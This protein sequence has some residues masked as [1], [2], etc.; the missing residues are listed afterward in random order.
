MAGWVEL[1][2]RLPRTEIRALYERADLFVAP[3][4]LE[5]FGIAALEA[6]CAGLPVLART[7][8]G[9][10]EFVGAR[11]DGLLAG[12]DGDLVRD[13]V[14]LAADPAER[15]RMAVTAGGSRSTWAG[16]PCSVAPRPP[17]PPPTRSSGPVVARS[18]CS[19][20]PASV[21]PAEPPVRV[22]RPALL[23]ELIVIL[24]LVKV[25]DQVRRLEVAQ[26]RPALH[27]ARRRAGDR[28]LAAPRPR[29]G[30]QPV[31]DRAPHAAA[32]SPA[33]GISWPTSR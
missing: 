14:R 4:T 25:Y 26:S 30:R 27:N 11:P 9:I 3:A 20:R 15:E 28:A 6:R 24:V 1:P 29:A 12:S 5:S 10:G 22:R 33:G 16:R 7:A 19:V 23:G 2:G 17:T 18:P 8:G 31:A 21:R 13:L 32:R